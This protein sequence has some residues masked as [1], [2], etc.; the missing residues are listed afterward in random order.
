MKT[1]ANPNQ[2]FTRW[3]VFNGITHPVFRQVFK[4]KKAVIAKVY[5]INHINILLYKIL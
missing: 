4:V 2:L 5:S 3:V 1:V